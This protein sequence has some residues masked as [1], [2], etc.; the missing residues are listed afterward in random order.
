ML[1][2]YSPGEVSLTIGGSIINSWNS[3]TVARNE[4]KNFATVGTQGE[5]TRTVNASKLG[6][7]TIVLPQ[8]SADNATLSAK[9]IS[10]GI[11]SIGVLDKSGNSIVT[12]AEG[13]MTGVAE[14]A[15]EKEEGEREWVFQG[16]LDAYVVGGN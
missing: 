13:F 11:E 6:T 16:S 7:I 2:T 9:E 8:A 10:N 5:V 3:I 4:D 1:K 14:S 15:F 12:M